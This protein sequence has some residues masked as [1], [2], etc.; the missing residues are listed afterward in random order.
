VGVYSPNDWAKVA[1][2]AVKRHNADCIVAEKNQGG[3]MVES[4]IR[5][6]DKLVRIKLVTATKGKYVRAEPIYSLYEQSKIFH[7]GRFPILEAQIG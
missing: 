1:V 6:Y 4:V 3:D 7:V 2:E 5:Q